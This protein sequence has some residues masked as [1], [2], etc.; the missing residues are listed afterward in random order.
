[1]KDKNVFFINQYATNLEDG[2]G[3]R[4]LAY[5]LA[6]ANYV[7]SVTLV[8]A[9]HHHLQNKINGCGTPRSEN[10]KNFNVIKLFTLSSAT[11]RNLARVLNWFLFALQ[12]MWTDK[13]LKIKPDIIIYSS[14]SPVGFLGAFVLSRR[15]GAKIIYEVR[16]IWPLT[17]VTI[18]KKSA[19]HP[20]VLLLGKIEEFSYSRCDGVISNLFGVQEYILN[21]FGFNRPFLYSPTIAVPQRDKPPKT[22]AKHE[23]LE[24]VKSLRKSKFVVGYCGTIGFANCLENLINSAKRLRDNKSILFV[25]IGRGEFKKKIECIIKGENLENVIILPALPKSLVGEAIKYFNVGYLGWHN[26]PLYE[27]G[28]GANKMIEYL[29]CGTPIIHAYSGQYD[30]V[31]DAGL[32]ASVPAEDAKAL[33]AAICELSELNDKDYHNLRQ[34]CISFS[35]EYFDAQKRVSELL[36]FVDDL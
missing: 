34:K 14:P 7:K 36:C 17:L 32:G 23:T 12:I 5:S 20:L 27:Y 22:I 16:D 18:G 31:N 1:M 6:I 2:F 24:I 19:Y 29:S 28:I 21:T 3:G 10:P 26:S 13:H 33:A 11:S 25:I 8:C 4:S 15:C 35:N 30:L 9:A